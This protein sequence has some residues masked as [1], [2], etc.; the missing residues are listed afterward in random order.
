MK[1]DNFALTMHQACPTR[2]WRRMEQGWEPRRKGAA[3]NFGGAIHA[4]LATWYRHPELDRTQRLALS[5]TS[6]EAAWLDTGPI[7]DYRTL[8]KCVDVMREYSLEYPMESFSIV[9]APERAVIEQ[10]FTIGLGTYL[11]CDKCVL[12]VTDD[13]MFGSKCTYCNADREII[14]YGGIFDGLAQ[15]G[16]KVYVLE[17]K[18]TSQLGDT[19]FTQFNPNNQVTGYIWAAHQ[20]S[21]LDVAG[22]MINAIGVYK[23]GKTRFRRQVTTRDE[24][25]IN[26]WRRNVTA[27]C[28]EIASHRRA[29]FWPQRTT[30]CTQYGLCAY[31][32]VCTLSETEWQERR[33]EQDYVK[34]TWDYTNRDEGEP[35]QTSS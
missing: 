34:S 18:S 15:F 31:H 16:D 21:G 8:S 27:T 32:Q 29:K 30:S 22:A 23:A 33:L 25:D 24:H 11:R 3:L 17:H 5:I 20:L 6:I 2:F 10:T 9:G 7:D 26:Q 12:G 13:D 19:F 14:E 1:I 35:A 28:E 4:G